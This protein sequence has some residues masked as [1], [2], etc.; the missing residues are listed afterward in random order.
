MFYG[1]NE[2]GKST[3]MNFLRAVLYGVTPQRRKRYLPPLAGGRP[4]GWL[5][6]G[7]RATGRYGS[8]ATP[9]AARRTSAR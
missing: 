5:Q 2:A 7:E 3:L 8:P 1:P 6:G 4:G 9:T